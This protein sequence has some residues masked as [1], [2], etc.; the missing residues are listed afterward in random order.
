MRR[1]INKIVSI[2]A[3]LMIMAVPVLAN[4]L[5]VIP[6]REPA[7]QNPGKDQCLIVAMNCGDRADSIQ[8]R[9]D[10]IQTEINKGSAVYTDDELGVLRRRLDAEKNDLKEAYSGGA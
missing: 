2:A 4:D 3:A 9:I 6:S 8:N 7:E 5:S 1:L 10:A